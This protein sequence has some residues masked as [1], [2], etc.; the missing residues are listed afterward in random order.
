MTDWRDSLRERLSGLQLRPEREIEIIEELSQHLDDHARELV[1]GGA[2]MS[3]A[4]ATALA[5]LDAPGELARR[6][7][8]I[9]RRP[10]LVLPPPGAP[11]RGRSWNGCGTTSRTPWSATAQRTSRLT[12]PLFTASE[13]RCATTATTC[14]PRFA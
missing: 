6:L 2:E 9:E 4:R 1:A 12:P 10:P 14:T 13:R 8:E 5:D 7:A 11:S 3:A